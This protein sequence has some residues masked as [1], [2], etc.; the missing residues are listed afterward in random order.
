MSSTVNSVWARCLDSVS[1]EVSGIAFQTWFQPLQP[2][3]LKQEGDR[4]ELLIELPSRFYHE[5]LDQHYNKLLHDTVNGVVGRAATVAYRIADRDESQAPRHEA[6]ESGIVRRLPPSP[7]RNGSKKR[8]ERLQVSP[9]P[10]PVPVQYAYSE[11]PLQKSY[12][13]ETFIEGD[14]NRLARSASLAIAQRPGQTSFNP[15]MIYGG[16]GL[17]KTH[18]VQAI[19]NYARTYGTTEKIVYL[20]SE[21]FTAEFVR[22]VKNHCIADFTQYYRQTDLL[23]VDD[24]Q[25]FGGKEKTQ[26]EFFHIF[27]DLHQRNK[28]VVLCA[29]RPP[30]EIA[31]IEERLLS[32]FQ[33]GLSADV[34]APDLETRMAILRNKAA[35]SGL[36]VPDEVIDFVAQRIRSNIRELE[37]ALTRLFAHARLQNRT[38]DLAF[39]YEALGDLLQE[40]PTHLEIE[41]IQRMVAD[42]YHLS[43]AI[44]CSRTRK[45]DVVNARQVA[46]YLAKQ[47]TTHTLEYIGKYFGGRDHSTVIHSCTMVENRMDVESAFADEVTR[48]R[49]S[50]NGV[51]S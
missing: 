37:G 11:H 1:R 27:N 14:C 28:Q 31:G 19:A 29:D 50:I 47:F 8:Q 44:I 15:F 26:E 46:I 2:V 22:S 34:Q 35:M 45:R 40:S 4:V 16:V 17:G 32:R 41:D 7:G 38:I 5:W 48:I 9:E 49:R 36:S 23:I 42:Y 18:L 33:W 6:D 21:Q 13:F 43:P 25:F 51:K 39:A 20:S 10:R 12:T 30:R 3:S 24:V